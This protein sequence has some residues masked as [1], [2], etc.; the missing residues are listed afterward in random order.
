MITVALE[1]ATTAAVVALVV[2][3][4][5]VIE[6][7]ASTN[8]HHTES[9]LPALAGLLAA[10]GKGP[11]D[12]DHIVVDV[13][14]GLFTGL[15]VG[16]ATARSLAAALGRGVICVSSLELLA[17]AVDEEA[18]CTAVVDARRGEVFVQSFTLGSLR[19]VP[20]T[21]AVV[22]A[23]EALAEEIGAGR[24]PSTLVGD[25]ALRYSAVL[26][27]AGARVLESPTIPSA[28]LAATMAAAGRWDAPVAPAEV[29]PHYVRDPDAVANFQ[30]AH[31]LRPRP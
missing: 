2:D 25:G 23:P 16:V 27:E 7:V 5:P 30:V 17:A 24:A 18:S 6:H 1:T 8:R 14:P 29:M 4:Q 12:I 9:L 26:D 10:A 22:L 28:A 13:G 3:D 31:A 19:P 11:H 21:A 20:S 15:R